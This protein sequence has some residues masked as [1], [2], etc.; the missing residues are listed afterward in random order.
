M[1]VSFDAELPR[2]SDGSAHV[3]FNPRFEGRFPDLG[4][5]GGTVSNCASCHERATFPAAD[6]LTG[7]RG[8]P[9]LRTDRAF[10]GGRISTSFLWSISLQAR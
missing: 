3:A 9:D 2:E 1:S 4:N 8:R 10:E 7:G 6:F 5:G